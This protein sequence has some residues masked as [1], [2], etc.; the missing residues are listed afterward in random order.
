M[1]TTF[2]ICDEL[3]ATVAAVLARHGDRTIVLVNYALVELMSPAERMHTLNR[4]FAG[5]EGP[6]TPRRVDELAAP[7]L[8][9]SKRANQ[10]RRSTER[11]MD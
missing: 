1:P 5:L 6:S 9:R 10:R 11:E 8:E 7:R 4:L 2:H 3:P